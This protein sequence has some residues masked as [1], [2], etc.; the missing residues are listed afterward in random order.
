MSQR[1][2]RF[3]KNISLDITARK[4]NLVGK[5]KKSM[6]N[7]LKSDEKLLESP[8]EK[9]FLLTAKHKVIGGELTVAPT[10]TVRYPTK[11]FQLNFSKNSSE[12]SQKRKK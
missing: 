8:R 12:S 7:S 1:R 10:P 5:Y 3:N 2:K 6:N 9:G 4:S 11:V